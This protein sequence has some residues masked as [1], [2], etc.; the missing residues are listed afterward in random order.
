[1]MLE[2]VLIFVL[3]LFIT[4][5]IGVPIVYGLGI[6]SL[7]YF[8]TTR[9]L[10]F[11]PDLIVIPMVQSVNSFLLLAVP[12]FFF[13]GRLMN[14]SGLTDRLFTFANAL[15]G[16][17]RG[18]LGHVNVLCSMIFAGMSGAAAADVAGPGAVEYKAMLDQ[19]YDKGLSAGVSLGSSV[20]GPII[21]PSIPVLIYASITEIS[22]TGLLMAG[23]VPGI[24]TGF[25]QMGV[26]AYHCRNRPRSRRATLLEIGTAF[27]KSFLTLLTP[28]ILVVGIGSGIFTAT[29]AGAV[30]GF[31]LLIIAVGVYRTVTLQKLILICRAV[32]KDTAIV[33]FLLASA[34]FYGWILTRLR[35]PMAVLEAL[36]SFSDN[37]YVIIGI[38]ILFLLVIGCFFSTAVGLVMVAPIVAPVASAVGFDPIHFGI[39]VIISMVIGTATPPVGASLYALMQVTRLPIEMISKSVIPF[40]IATLVV[41]LITVF[42][43]SLALFFPRLILGN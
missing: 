15:V 42:F 14:E 27:K 4:I 9:G 12:L 22:A 29:E 30:A 40:L 43:P 39:I 17:V 37:P 36:L 19:G 25:A 11:P 6:A 33:M 20:I 35:I 18:G 23:L 28:V 34:S 3:V 13:V 10:G 26:V 21:P 2:V 1:M 24:L 41:I 31:Y 16:H 5:A 7:I 8:F 32:V 38:I